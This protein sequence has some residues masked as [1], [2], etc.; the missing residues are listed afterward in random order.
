MSKEYGLEILNEVSSEMW[1]LKRRLEPESSLT[2]TRG[3]GGQST[4]GGKEQKGKMDQ[5]PRE[6]FRI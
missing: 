3:T 4:D 1:V 2:G 5:T 6:L